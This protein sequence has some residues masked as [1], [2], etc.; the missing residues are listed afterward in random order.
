MF[1]LSSVLFPGAELPLHVFEP[2]YRELTDDCLAGDGEFGVVLIARGSE[3]GGGDQRFGVGTVAHIEAASPFDDGRWA[4]LAE[5][6]AGSPWRGGWPTT[7]IRWPRSTNSPTRRCRPTRRSWTGPRRR[8]AGSG[9]CCRSWGR[10]RRWWPIRGAGADRRRTARLR[11]RRRRRA[12][13]AAVRHWPRSP[14]STAKAARGRSTGS[15]VDAADRAVRGPG[16]GSVATARR[17]VRDLRANAGSGST[18]R[19]GGEE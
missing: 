1:P 17:P 7:P 11:W 18:E 4:L 16:R 13:V 14:P 9:P 15:P 6:G 8:C 19:A 10:R 5:G 12:P 3:V 2:R